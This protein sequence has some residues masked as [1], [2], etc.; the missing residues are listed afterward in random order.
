MKSEEIKNLL[1]KFENAC[2]NYKDI[3]CWSA[4]NCKKFIIIARRKDF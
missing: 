3:E 2:Y 1:E 4:G